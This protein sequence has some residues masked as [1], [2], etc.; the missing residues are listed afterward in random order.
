MAIVGIV[1]T[2]FGIIALLDT[3]ISTGLLQAAFD[4]FFEVWSA[5]QLYTIYQAINKK[6]YWL[7]KKAVSLMQWYMVVLALS[8]GANVRQTSGAVLIKNGQVSAGEYVFVVMLSIGISEGLFYLFY[9]FGAI[10]VRNIL[11]QVYTLSYAN[12]DYT[13]MV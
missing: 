1:L 7:A 2:V 8:I 13:P 6:D 4:I 12:T 10:K 9:L 3:S 11:D 5:Y